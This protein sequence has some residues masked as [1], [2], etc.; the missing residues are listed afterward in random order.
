MEPKKTLYIKGL[1]DKQ[2]ANEI[3]RAL[4]LHCTQYG[5]VVSLDASYT[6]ASFM[7]EPFKFF[8]LTLFPLLWIPLSDGEE[9]FER[10]GN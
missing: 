4:Y 9:I 7:V 3:R 5:P 2:S 8:M 6:T 10:R 1:P